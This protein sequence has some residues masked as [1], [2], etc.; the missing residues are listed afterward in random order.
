MPAP[1]FADACPV[2]EARETIATLVER[3]EETGDPKELRPT[4]KALVNGRLGACIDRSNPHGRDAIE[5][6][7][8]V[9]EF[10]AFDKLTK[11]Y[12]PKRALMYTPAKIDYSLR[13]FRAASR[14]LY[15]YL[16]ERRALP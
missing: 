2:A 12:E 15:L 6:L 13:A 8:S 7:A 9:V 10:D 1:A 16:F 14:E 5:Y 4:A 3:V 11:N